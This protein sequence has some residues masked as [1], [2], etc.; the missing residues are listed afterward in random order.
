MYLRSIAYRA[1]DDFFYQ[2]HISWEFQ[3]TDKNSV[4]FLRTP[5][6]LLH[7]GLINIKIVS[8]L[9]DFAQPFEYFSIFWIFWIFLNIFVYICK[10]AERGRGWGKILQYHRVCLIFFRSE[11]YPHDI[12]YSNI[13]LVGTRH[14]LLF[15]QFYT[16]WRAI[17]YYSKY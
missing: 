4:L 9:L 14:T 15:L 10:I 6:N 5:H 3:K 13:I 2:I 8:S 12:L 11:K 16:I 1:H 17:I 7:L